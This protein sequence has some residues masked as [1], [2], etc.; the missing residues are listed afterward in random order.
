MALELARG[1]KRCEF[2]AINVYAKVMQQQ[3][4]CAGDGTSDRNA[5]RQ[6]CHCLECTAGFSA[7]VFLLS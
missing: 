6:E 1:C 5:T 3:R 4:A 7:R 2:K